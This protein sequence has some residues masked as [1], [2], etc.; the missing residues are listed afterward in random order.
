MKVGKLVYAFKGGRTC[1]HRHHVDVINLGKGAKY[2]CTLPRQ[3]FVVKTARIQ[4]IMKER[5]LYIHV[6]FCLLIFHSYRAHD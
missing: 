3:C 1:T 5:D 4:V 2:T 6:S